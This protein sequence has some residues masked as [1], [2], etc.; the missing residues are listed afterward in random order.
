MNLKRAG[1]AVIVLGAVCGAG[2][3][4][5][6][7]EATS[8]TV[9]WGTTSSAPAGSRAELF[10]VAS[11]SAADALAVGGFNPGQPPTAVL[12]KPYAERWN[13]TGWTATRVPLGSV[14]LPPAVQAAQLNG[15]ADIAPGDGWAVGSVS[16]ISSLASKTL[17]YHWDGAAWRR[18][19]TPNPG[20]PASGTQLDAV[21][22]RAADDV[23]AVGGDGYPAVSLVLHWNGSTWAQLS[24]PDIGSLDT[25][26][27]APGH[28][29]VAGG[30]LVEQFDGTAW[31]SLPAPPPP[32]ETSVSIAGLA[33]N[34]SG[35]WAAGAVEFTC[36]EGGTC[37]AP[38]A[39]LWNGTT[40]TVVLSG[41]NGEISSVVAAGSK[42]LA[43]SGTGVLQ[44]TTTGAV[45]QVT[46]ALS[47]LQLTAIAAD[48]AGNPWAVGWTAAQGTVRP[49]I[50][51]APGIGQ[52]GIIV[53]TGA[54][55]ATV[56]WTGPVNGTGSTD[57]AGRFATGGLPDATY[58]ITA[59]LPGCQ[60][61]V[62]TAVV[63]AGIATTLHAHPT[64]PP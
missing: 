48:P 4:S 24:V 56:T 57:P 1:R 5:A 28:V 53:T 54:S 38:Y 20:G 40:W 55:A 29:W 30:D 39:A 15:V 44:L 6:A 36:G 21:A 47:P 52:G 34:A 45:P 37:T 3:S 16:D 25:V 19:P 10:G 62:A 13:G 31:T 50:I 2:L 64:C 14:Y 51:N 12:T 32:A 61:G 41:G 23:W 33:H 9:A 63:T 46:P 11:A 59:S 42:V 27:L 22:A 26:T 49:A 17:A 35:L 18:T 8:Q 7:A 43:A 60:P 58:T